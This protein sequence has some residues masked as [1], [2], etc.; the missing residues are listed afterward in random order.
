MA[1][2]E[3]LREAQTLT[4]ATCGRSGEDFTFGQYA[5]DPRPFCL[6][7]PNGIGVECY[8]GRPKESVVARATGEV[9]VEETA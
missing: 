2:P 1:K 6:R 3:G 7:G 4:C 9:R 5:D 8:R